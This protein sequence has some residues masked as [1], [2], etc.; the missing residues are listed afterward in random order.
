MIDILSEFTY[1]LNMKRKKYVDV[2]TVDDY[3]NL[4]KKEREFMGLYKLPS[5]L[6][7]DWFKEKEKGWNFFY[8]QIKKE[9][10]LQW[11]FR[12][13]LVSFENP[14][15][16]IYKK[17]DWFFRDTKY[18]INN[19]IKPSHPR[20][21]KTLPRHKYC[22]TYELFIDSSYNLILDFYYEEVVDGYVDWEA[23]DRHKKFYDELVNKVNW[24]EREKKTMLQEIDNEL[25]QICNKTKEICTIQNKDFSKF[26]L[27]E[28]ELFDKETEIIKWFA[29]N[30]NYFWT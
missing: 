7:C 17:I 23:D 19:F 3:F 22:N 9:Y 26:E 14:L 20:W 27:L 8:S 21:R 1:I 25:K 30:R 15:Y 18:A 5:A 16:K 28:K 11:F 10:P 24:I 4:P 13:W 6:P 12:C 29:E 2:T